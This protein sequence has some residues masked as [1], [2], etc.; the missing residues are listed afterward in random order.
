ML[1]G[2][3]THINTHSLVLRNEVSYVWKPNDA[4]DLIPFEDD[5]VDVEDA[6]IM[7]ANR[8]RLVDGQK[9]MYPKRRIK[10]WGI[11]EIQMGTRVDRRKVEEDLIEL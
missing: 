11:G 3:Q 5:K 7:R 10:G 4:Q 6:D 2:P 1:R 9:G 8:A